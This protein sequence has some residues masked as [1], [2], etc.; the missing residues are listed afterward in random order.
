MDIGAFIAGLISIGLAVL[1]IRGFIWFLK[2][3]WE[4]PPNEKFLKK[5]GKK[6]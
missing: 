1:F 4:Q 6:D 2:E 5:L 3:T